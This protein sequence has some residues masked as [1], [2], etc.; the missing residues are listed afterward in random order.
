MNNQIRDFLLYMIIPYVIDTVLYDQM[1][2]VV[3]SNSLFYIKQRINANS[4]A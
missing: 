2:N 3:K 4:F 1:Q